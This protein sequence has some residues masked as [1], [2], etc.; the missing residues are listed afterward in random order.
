MT[1]RTP[2]LQGTLQQAAISV[3][4]IETVWREDLGRR[5]GILVC[6][7]PRTAARERDT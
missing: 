5:Q 1:A 4:D 6:G 3:N 7:G 2:V